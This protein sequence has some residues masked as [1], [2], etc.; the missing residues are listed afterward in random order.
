M[1][2]HHQLCTIKFVHLTN[3]V[4]PLIHI[5]LS[6]HTLLSPEIQMPF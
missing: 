6:V 1:N 2:Y 5:R 3:T 4:S